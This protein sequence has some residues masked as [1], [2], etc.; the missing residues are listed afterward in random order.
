MNSGS[1]PPKVFISYSHDSEEHK[2]RV[3]EL[4]DHLIKGGVDCNIDQYEVSPSEGWPRWMM[5]QLDWAEFVLVICTEVYNRRFRGH[6]EAGKGRGVTWEGGIISQELY[7]THSKS[8]KFIPIVF[9]AQDREHIPIVI[10]GYTSYLLEQ[11]YFLLYRYITNQPQNTKPALGHIIPL[12]PL[13]RRDRQQYFLDETHYTNLRAEFLDASKGLLNWQRTLGNDQ[14]IDRLELDQLLNRIES[15]ESSTTIVLGIPGSG[16]SALLATLGHRVVDKGYVLLAIKADYLSNTINNLEDLQNDDQVHLSMNPRDAIKAVANKERIVLLIDQLDAVAE[17]L[18]K[19]PGRL[20]VLLN[21]IQS[22]A[23]TKG[24]HIIATCREFEFHHGSQFARLKGFEPLF[25]SLPTWGQVSP[26]LEKEGHIPNSMGEPLQEL[27]QNPLHLKLFFEVAKPGEVFDSSQK[28]LDKLWENRILNQPKPEKYIDFLERLAQRMK[29]EEVLWLPTSVADHSVEVSRY[30]E[31]AG[32]LMLNRDNSTLG[33][34]HQTY[35]DY[36]LARTFARGSSASLVD[37]VLERQDG[38]FVRPILLRS[39]NYVRGTSPQQYQQQ[40]RILLKNADVNNHFLKNQVAKLALKSLSHLSGKIRLRVLNFWQLL[41]LIYVRTHIYTLLIEFVGSQNKPELIEAE[42]LIPL[43]NSKTEGPKVLD[44][45]I[46]SPGWFTR[47][48]HSPEFWQWLEKQPNEAAYCFSILF[49]ATQFAVDDVWNLLE[50][51]WLN[52]AR[53]DVLSIRIMLNIQQWNSEKVWHAEQIIRRSNIDWYSVSVIAERVLEN[54][55]DLASRI[56]R[57]HLDYKLEQAIA[58]SNKPIPELPPDADEAERY[59]HAYRHNTKTFFR[60]LLENRSNFYKLEIF[61]IRN[62]KAFLIYV[63]SWF[64]DILSR[65]VDQENYQKNR[66]YEDNLI[67]LD[68]DRG[69]IIQV[70]LLAIVQIAKQDKQSF[71]DFFGKNISSDFLLIHRLIAHG[72]VEIASEEPQVVLNYLLGDARRFTLGD[73]NNVYKETK[74]LIESVCPYL[75][76]QDIGGIEQAIRKFIYYSVDRELSPEIKLNF[77]QYNRQHQLRLLFTIPEQYL[78]SDATRWRNELIRAFPWIV[79]GKEESYPTIAHIVGSPMTVEE[80]KRASDKNLLNLFNELADITDTDYMMRQRNLSRAGGASSQAYDFSKLVKDDPDRFIRILPQL[81]PQRHEMYAG[82]ALREIAET[83]FPVTNLIQLVESLE[84]RGF[85]SEEYRSDAASALEKIAER[86]LGLPQSILS[87]LENWL[88]THTKPD[89]SQYRD[90][91]KKGSHD[92]KTPVLFGL[93]GSHFLPD[94]RGAIVRALT[95]GYLKQNPPDLE[96]WAKFIKSQLEVEQHP[97][98]WVDILTAMPALLNGDRTQATELFDK[99]IRNCPQIFYYRFTLFCIS[100][101]VGWFEPQEIV[102]GWLEM[103]LAEDSSFCH[104]VYGELLLIHYFQYQDEW[105]VARIHHHLTS[106]DNEAI[107]CGLAHAA[108]YLWGQNRC[109]VIAAEILYCLAHST[110]EVI[111]SAV[112]NVFSRS[113]EH[114]ELDSGMRQLIQAVCNNKPVLLKAA[115]DIIEIIEDR[116]LVDTEPQVVSE[117]C[118]SILSKVGTEI[119]NPAIALAL[120]AEILTT[121]VIKLHRQDNYREIGLKLFEQLLALNLRETLSALEVLDRR[122]NRPSL[123]VAPT[124]GTL[125]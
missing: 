88:S 13:P 115:S 119:R 26:L 18:D 104:Q 35:Y 109:R 80:M 50:R 92:L 4:A 10:R 61:A 85:V 57:A 77:L 17:L 97:A 7:D 39:L 66:Y 27:L 93:G 51:Y 121:I 45:M 70:F 94:G 124:R 71:I 44:A 106:Q 112:A 125:Q 25:L 52:E 89:L 34:C 30:L 60:N 105:S 41:Q 110:I 47:L 24:I 15:E 116:N 90:E 103:L 79:N 14:H 86:N 114:F 111:Q 117:I 54:L 46:G 99:V 74:L 28:L 81:E 120:V 83:D 9:C 69:E 78:S 23:G 2:K 42:L 31:Q 98:V 59:V 64:T 11:E 36:T 122:P 33:F 72:L 19:L 96:N 20:N 32:I 101:N 75:Q 123:Y 102:Q 118:Q 107:L 58:E 56:I 113:Q 82:Y 55:P 65:I 12:P 108:S 95:D 37:L 1:A 22:I 5:N 8:N 16:K 43:L 100:R 73:S 67:S 63:W 29:D 38:L 3:L 48:C 62:P 6:E 87:L 40:L 91:E 84:Q 21:L 49:T 53:Y 68:F 76:P